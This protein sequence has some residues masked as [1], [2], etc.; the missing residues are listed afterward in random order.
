M[1]GELV[2]R[3]NMLLNDI[4]QN[5][6]KDNLE[7][8]K[9]LCK[10]H[11]GK[12]KLENI[13]SGIQLFQVLEELNLLSPEDTKTLTELLAN[14]QRP[15]LQIKL[16]TFQKGNGHLQQPVCEVGAL[17]EQLN[18]AFGVICNGV[19]KDWRMFARKL[20]HKEPL[21]QQIEYRHPHDMREQILQALI[22]WQK[23]KGK[24]ATVKTL[25]TA[26]RSC[27]LNMVADS[28]EEEVDKID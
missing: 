26:L 6:T 17:T 7:A 5:L 23:T 21:L 9:F 1:A 25:I 24:E 10:E 15:D 12:R 28:V 18:V 22:E 19:G 3:F 13:G 27:R 14:I 4:S 2:M 16:S 20:G 11:I 8:L